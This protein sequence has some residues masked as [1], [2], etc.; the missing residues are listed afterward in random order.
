MNDYTNHLFHYLP[1]ERIMTLSCGHVI[2]PSNLLATPIISGPKGLDF[3]FTFAQRNS[4]TM[5]HEL[6]HTIFQLTR[7][8]PHGLVV[9]FPSYAY[10]STAVTH[11]QANTSLWSLITAQ[12]RVF[13]ELK[14][15]SS[16]TPSV[17]PKTSNTTTPSTDTLL[18][19]Y[20]AHIASNHGAL[21]LAV[22]GGS[23]SEGINFSDRLGRGI[24]VVG[25]PF[26]NPHSPEWKAKLEYVAHRNGADGGKKDAAGIAGGNAEPAEIGGGRKK[27]AA[28]ASVQKNLD[29]A[30]EFYEN[31]CM[32]AVNQSVGRAIR[33]KDDYAAIMLI[34]RR[35]GR[36]NI[37]AKLPE[38]IRASLRPEEPLGDVVAGVKEFFA[39][40]R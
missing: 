28:G 12:K 33:H 10:L 20:T 3:D 25:L 40:E 17:H 30:R 22:I 15:T 18:S 37:K 23:L 34:D 24:V 32:R 11:W 39:V 1:L 38:W 2:P 4:V 8:I 36:E 14:S 7:V 6:G 31:A 26:P 27:D 9:F 13:L 29:P 35:Y 19:S 21:L 5:L 16:S